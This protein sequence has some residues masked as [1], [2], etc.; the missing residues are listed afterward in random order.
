MEE[1]RFLKEDIRKLKIEN[2]KIKQNEN[3]MDN[4]RDKSPSDDNS[5]KCSQCNYVFQTDK[6]LRDHI[7]RI[8]EERSPNFFHEVKI[9]YVSESVD[10]AINEIKE[11]YI[12][13]FPPIDKNTIEYIQE[14]SGRLYSEIDDN[15]DQGC[16][17]E[18][19]FKLLIDSKYD[20]EEVEKQIFADAV[21]K[22]S[23]LT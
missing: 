9:T 14:E 1:V 13:K 4:V 18:Y 12:H 11:Y 17:K 16:H 21:T 7:S 15:Y 3:I 23:F 5:V 19:I 8:H 10:D 6:Q 2:D 22:F 20:K